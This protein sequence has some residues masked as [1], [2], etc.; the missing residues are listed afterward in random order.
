MDL[1]EG[2]SLQD[3][4][5]VSGIPLDERIAILWVKQVLRALDYLHHRIP[6]VVHLEVFPYNMLVTQQGHCVLIN[7]SLARELSPGPTAGDRG[8]VRGIVP[9]YSPPEQYGTFVD[10]RSDIYSIGAT[11]Y[12]ILTGIVPLESIERLTGKQMTLPRAI[13]DRIS[14]QTER[15]ILRAM[16]LARNDRFQS[17]QEMIDALQD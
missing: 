12:Y 16:A 4:V 2:K 6:P 17:A 9:G 13:T 8:G 1:V 14:L 10:Q 5:S 3:L 11:L 7:F 15:V